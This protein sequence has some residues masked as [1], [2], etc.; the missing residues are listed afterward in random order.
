MSVCQSYVTILPIC[1]IKM[2][3]QVKGL[4]TNPLTLSQTTNFRLSQTERVCRYNENDR[5]FYKRVENTEGKEEIARYE[6][7]LLFLQSFKKLLM[8]TCKNTG[9]RKHLNVGKHCM[10]RT[11]SW[12]SAFSPFYTMFPVY[13]RQNVS[14]KPFPNKPLFLRVCSCPTSL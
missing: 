13:Q 12:S 4:L 14:L 8:W 6:Q 3:A 1:T 2:S 10:T 5:K 11:K 7:F 9:M